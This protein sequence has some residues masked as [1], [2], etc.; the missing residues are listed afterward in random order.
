MAVVPLTLTISLCL[1][2]T[3]VVFFIKEHA[4]QRFSSSESDALLPLSDERPHIMSADLGVHDT[5]SSR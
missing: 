3:F 5:R 2:F 1:V 4:R